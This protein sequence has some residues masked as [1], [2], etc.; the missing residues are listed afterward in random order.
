[1][2][3]DDEDA[4]NSAD[5]GKK[6]TGPPPKKKAVRGKSMN[7]HELA[8][9]RGALQ[10]IESRGR[11]HKSDVFPAHRWDFSMQTLQLEFPQ[12]AELALKC[13]RKNC[14]ET[15]LMDH[16]IFQ[17]LQSSQDNKLQS[18][19]KKPFVMDDSVEPILC[20]PRAGGCVSAAS[21]QRF[22]GLQR[23]LLYVL[24]P[25]HC[26]PTGGRWNFLWPRIL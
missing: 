10:A 3:E 22:A 7:P 17:R 12:L 19:I 15:T 8:A 14:P 26:W 21:K 11:M 20:E 4:T 9:L 5:E 23:F 18:V 1:M 6:D 16:E 24:G 2:E 13:F 25:T